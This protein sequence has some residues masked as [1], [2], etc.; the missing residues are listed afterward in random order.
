MALIFERMEQC[1]KKVLDDAGIVRDACFRQ[2]RIKI[3]VTN[4]AKPVTNDQRG[5]TSQVDVVRHKIPL[6]RQI[7]SPRTPAMRTH[8]DEAVL[9]HVQARLC[10]CHFA[11][12]TFVN[13]WVRHDQPC[14]VFKSMNSHPILPKPSRAGAFIGHF[15]YTLLSR[16]CERVRIEGPQEIWGYVEDAQSSDAFS[17]EP[18]SI[19]NRRKVVPGRIA[20]NEA[21]A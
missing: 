10:S 18:R 15:P 1:G 14:S 2:L 21:E 7:N 19:V 4:R 6:L 17:S 20:V 5:L 8:R 12:R 11:M 3:C 16:P 13:Q 9:L